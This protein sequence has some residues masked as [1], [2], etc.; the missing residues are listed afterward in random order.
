MRKFLLSLEDPENPLLG[1]TIWGLQ[2]WGMW[3]PKPGVNR[4]IYNTIHFL[5]ILFVLT[6]Y[7]ELWFIRS[8]MN[9]AM[10][11]LSVT[12]LSTV[13]VIKAGTFI[14]WQKHWR[15]IASYVSI[16]EKYQ[17]SK[18]DTEEHRI[19]QDYIQY[20][21]TVT[22]SYWGLVTATVLTV[23]LAPFAVFLSSSQ[24]NAFGNET[25]LYPEIL[26]SWAPFDRTQG[27]S[28]TTLV[29]KPHCSGQQKRH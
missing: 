6:Q 4:A 29:N 2:T 8:D 7:V 3:Q 27:K 28:R 16:T 13:C 9:M 17:L 5:A 22:Y 11:N 20:S 19:I 23:I 18:N 26:S 14:A 21:R 25:V 12:M 1:P 24:Y 15:S 10:R